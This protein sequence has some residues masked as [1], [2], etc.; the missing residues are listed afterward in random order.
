MSAAYMAG[1]EDG[2]RAAKA[3]FLK[4]VQEM[5][6]AAQRVE[7]TYLQRMTIVVCFSSGKVSVSEV[8]RKLAITYAEAQA[9]C[10]SIVDLG[11][12]DGLLLAP[13][14]TRSSSASVPEQKGGAA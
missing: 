12:A 8:Q 3:E 13:S 1:F 4:L 9:L 6:P 2:V 14:L 11:L 7:L 10:Q 5:Q